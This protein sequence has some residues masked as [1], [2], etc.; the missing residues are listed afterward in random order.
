MELRTGEQ[1]KE[2]RQGGRPINRLLTVESRLTI[3]GGRVG[4]GMGGI[5][6]GD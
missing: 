3:A 1:G 4:E 6:G 5:G 2:K